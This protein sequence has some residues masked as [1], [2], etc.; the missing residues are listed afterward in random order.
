MSS[1][2]YMYCL[3]LSN[4]E[5]E[6]CMIND[7]PYYS[8]RTYENM[9]FMG[10]CYDKPQK[11]VEVTIPDD[12]DMKHDNLFTD[13][14]NIVN[15]YDTHD[16]KF[17]ENSSVFCAK[18]LPYIIRSNDIE[19]LNKISKFDNKIMEIFENEMFCTVSKS[20]WEWYDKK[21]RKNKNLSSENI[22][23]LTMY[24]NVEVLD[25]LLHNGYNFKTVSKHM[26]ISFD[27]LL[28]FASTPYMAF[29][30]IP[31]MERK[32]AYEWFKNNAEALAFDN[33]LSLTAENIQVLVATANSFRNYEF[34][35]LFEADLKLENNPNKIQQ[36]KT[37]LLSTCVASLQSYK[38]CHENGHCDVVQ[39]SVDKTPKSYDTEIITWLLENG[40]KVTINTLYKTSCDVFSM[41][42]NLKKFGYKMC[43]EEVKFRVEPI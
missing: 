41:N 13:K 29:G 17:I 1:S 6:T 28:V 7:T 4:G 2:K 34:L 39:H 9:Y 20:T 37:S 30:S 31:Y 36:F 12:A 33:T 42:E 19:T 24:G 32:N 23:K 40:Y 14:I 21:V 27:V 26:N 16:I 10:F 35:G 11:F 3:R 18:H 5:L 22:Q 38:W 43:I 15:E 25:W 8:V